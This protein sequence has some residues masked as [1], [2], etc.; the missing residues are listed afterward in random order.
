[1]VD[2]CFICLAETPP[3]TATC[4]PNTCHNLKAH[5]ACLRGGSKVCVICKQ[6]YL[7]APPDEPDEPS[8]MS[9]PGSSEVARNNKMAMVLLI[10]AWACVAFTTFVTFVLLVI[11]IQRIPAGVIAALCCCMFAVTMIAYIQIRATLVYA[12]ITGSYSFET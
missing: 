2:H 8:T 9:E 4:A 6:P 3:L 11:Y 5:I 10:G 1:M 12:G 7:H